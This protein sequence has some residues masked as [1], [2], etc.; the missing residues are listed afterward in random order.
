[1]ELNYNELKNILPHAYPFLLL[2]RVVEVKKG[3]SL[4]AVKNITANEWCFAEEN[5]SLQQSIPSSAR[6]LVFQNQGAI[7]PEVL[8]I[9]AAA[10]AALVLY[11][12]SKVK[13]GDRK[14]IYKFGQAKAEFIKSSTFASGF[15][16]FSLFILL[17]TPL[18][19]IHQDTYLFYR[20]L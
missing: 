18:R 5:S 15:S 6:D 13:P 7:F 10:Q 14:P 11:E 4:V 19:Y 8:L 3:E 20:I 1:M 2:D 17:T 12:V 9:E 16:V